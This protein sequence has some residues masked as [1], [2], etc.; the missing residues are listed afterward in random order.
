MTLAFIT[1]YIEIFKLRWAGIGFYDEGGWSDLG[2]AISTIISL[3]FGEKQSR[4]WSS[5]VLWPGILKATIPI[6]GIEGYDSHQGARKEPGIQGVQ[7]VDG[8][9]HFPSAWLDV[10]CVGRLN[11]I[12]IIK[13]LAQ[14]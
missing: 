9:I 7:V 6:S 1:W 2:E 11:L 4:L 14:F 10:E 13:Y 8:R 5:L 3:R 12:S